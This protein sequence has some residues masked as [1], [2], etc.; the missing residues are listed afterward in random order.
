MYLPYFLSH[1][2]VHIAAKSLVARG[3]LTRI[4]KEYLS[5]PIMVPLEGMF[6]R[7]GCS[8]LCVRYI[9]YSVGGMDSEIDETLPCLLIYF[10][11]SRNK[12]IGKGVRGRAGGGG[13]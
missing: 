1:A 12:R 4:V 3:Y 7:Q 2:G 13:G 9:I 10:L 6:I 5:T 11:F 8:L